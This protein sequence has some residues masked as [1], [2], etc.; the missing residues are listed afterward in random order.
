[1]ESKLINRSKEVVE[2]CI[3]CPLCRRECAFLGQYGNPKEIAARIDLRDDAT[4]TL[5]YKCSLCGLCGA[6]C[7][8]H[9]EP[10]NLFLEMR[11]TAV[12]RGIAPFPEHKMLL[13]YENRGISKRYSCYA[14]PEG[15]E[16]VFFPGC[17]LPGTRPQRTL[18]V[19]NHL[20][21]LIPTLGMV[22]DCCTKPSHDLG[23]QD[24]FIAA[25]GE[26]KD[27]LVTYGVRTVLT[28][29]PNCYRVFKEY[30]DGLGVKTVYE[31]L[32]EQGLN[33]TAA[34]LGGKPVVIHDP[35]AIRGEAPVHDAVRNLTQKQGLPV[36]EMPH[37]GLRTLC[38]GEGGAVGLLVPE[39]S[40][41]WGQKRKT[42]ADHREMITYCVGCSSLLRKLTPTN[43]LLDRIFDPEATR[44]GRVKPP[45]PPWTY[46][47]RLKLKRQIK[48]SVKAPVT[49]ERTLNIEPADK[50]GAYWRIGLLLVL[51]GAIIATRAVGVTRYLEQENLRNLIQDAGLWAPAIYMLTYTLAPV[52]FLPGLPITIIGGILF[53][54]FWGVVYS[55]VGA[56]AGACLAFLVSRYA[57]RG[58]IEY[59][60]KSP[61][62][63]KLD[64]GVEKQGWKI[65]ALTRLIPL[66]P[67]NLLNYAFGLTKI[68]L[69]PYALA[70]SLFMLPACIAFI[71]LSSSLLD[72]LKGRM[73]KEI[74]IG[75]LLI[76]AVSLI[77]VIYRKLKRN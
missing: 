65:V 76:V 26:M 59:K 30:G 14:L 46:W 31:V 9:L 15:C 34:P 70:T 66:F 56:T 54:P 51:I 42:E 64:E 22:L 35:C 63:K 58:W 23:R 77:P 49:R 28:A 5:A 37:H 40:G 75:L 7:P 69:V 2:K 71:V 32:A 61:R 73:S 27:Y 17:G 38:C 4:L 74:L 50:R 19:Y 3:S 13:A 55:I 44:L 62:W 39:L 67:F 45:G 41:Q 6:V 57:A 48:K 68:G 12:A 16:T 36:E 1:M 11:R 52:L 18:Q 25:F 10:R 8:V 29:C 47:N 43:H 20:R 72:L 21:S 24:F 53:G 60:L 33:K